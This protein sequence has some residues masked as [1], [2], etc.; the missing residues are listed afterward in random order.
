VED[1]KS[2]PTGGGGLFGCF[3]GGG[4]S[5]SRKKVEAP[6]PQPRAAEVTKPANTTTED[7]KSAKQAKEAA[8][9]QAKET[10]KEEAKSA[11]EAKEAAVKSKMEGEVAAAQQAKEAKEAGG[12]EEQAVGGSEASAMGVKGADKAPKKAEKLLP[13]PTCQRSFGKEPLEKH[14]KI[15][16]KVR[17]RA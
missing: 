5:K 2:Q 13:C 3:G 9:K 15:C 6:K 17:A 16:K 4:S 14:M 12:L 10:K 8:A 11:K 1:L 7:A